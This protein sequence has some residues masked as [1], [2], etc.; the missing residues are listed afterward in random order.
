M[1]KVLKLFIYGEK[2]YIFD[3]GNGDEKSIHILYHPDAQLNE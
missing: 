1:P 2:D 3:E